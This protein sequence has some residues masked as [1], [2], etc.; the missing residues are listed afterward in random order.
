M[1]MNG[2]ATPEGTSRTRLVSKARAPNHF[3][4]EQTLILLFIGIGTYLGNANGGDRPKLHRRNCSR[5]NN[6]E[7]TLS[8]PLAKL[9]LFNEV[10]GRSEKPWRS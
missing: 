2:F 5:S 8:T 1:T 6:S 9:S 10:N 4:R 3:R 7:R